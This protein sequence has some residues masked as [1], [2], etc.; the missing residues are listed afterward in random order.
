MTPAELMAI[1]PEE[2]RDVSD[3]RLAESLSPLFPASRTPFIAKGEETI[4]TNEGKRFSRRQVDSA[5]AQLSSILVKAGH[6]IPANTL[7]PGKHL[8]ID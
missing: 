2:L 1:R 4:T 8:L 3:D 6:N 5:V 7:P